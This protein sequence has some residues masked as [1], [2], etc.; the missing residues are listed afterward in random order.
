MPSAPAYLISGLDISYQKP[1]GT[2]DTTNSSSPVPSITLNFAGSVYPNPVASLN[3][4]TFRGGTAATTFQWDL[5]K[6]PFLASTV[7][8]SQITLE[9]SGQYQRLQENAGKSGKKADLALGNLKLEFPISSGVSFPL[10]ITVANASEQIKETYTKANFGISF[11]LDKL[12]SLL[13]ANQ[14]TQ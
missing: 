1:T 8:K 7:D 5:G 6:S 3:E 10:S 12:A 2:K 13:K 9:L 11:D 14:S 4:Q